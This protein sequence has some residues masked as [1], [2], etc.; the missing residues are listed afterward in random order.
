MR[1]H[2]TG[3]GGVSK[4][5][6]NTDGN[7]WLVVGV[8]RVGDGAMIYACYDVMGGRYTQGRWD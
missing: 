4:W 5:H 8:M 2:G 1:W 7:A 3:Y 6:R